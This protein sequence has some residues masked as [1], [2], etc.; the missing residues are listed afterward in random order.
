VCPCAVMYREYGIQGRWPSPDPLR[1]GAFN[2]ADPQSL[3]LYAYVRNT[4]TSFVDPRG[5]DC[6]GTV[7]II[8]TPNGTSEPQYAVYCTDDNGGGGLSG[9]GGGAGG[10]TASLP[11]S[12][13]CPPFLAGAISSNMWSMVNPPQAPQ[14]PQTPQMASNRQATSPGCIQT[15][16]DPSCKPSGPPPC[17]DA[18]WSGFEQGAGSVFPSFP[19][20]PGAGTED[21]AVNATAAAAAA[22]QMSRA[23]VMPLKSW[24]Y[25]G[26]T[27]VETGAELLG[28]IE[29]GAGAFWGDVQLA[30]QKFIDR[31]CA[32]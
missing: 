19:A 9:G 1:T 3:N 13:G 28:V 30:K 14:A 24:A 23:L 21:A 17:S 32:P 5:L 10:C 20:P 8:V 4:P 7:S 11:F 22:Y 27:Y 31:S 29:V 16:L 6:Q 18:F 12:P 15:V 2:L 25:R 26:L